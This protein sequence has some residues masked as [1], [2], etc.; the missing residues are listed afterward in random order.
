[1]VAPKSVKRLEA[2]LKPL[3]RQGRGMKLADTIERINRITRGW[4][5]YFRLSGVKD[6]FNKLDSWI[7]YHLRDIQWRQWKTRSTRLRKI[8]ALGVP[9]E[10]AK[11]ASNRCGPWRNAMAPHMHAALPNAVLSRLGLVS[12]LQEHQRLARVS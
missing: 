7:R 9:Y 3:L 1:M 11:S 4:V 12:L 5:A 2:K 10:Q 6:H 8:L